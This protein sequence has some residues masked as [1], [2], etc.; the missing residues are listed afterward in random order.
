MKWR[1]HDFESPL[2]CVGHRVWNHFWDTLSGILRLLAGQDEKKNVPRLLGRSRQHCVVYFLTIRLL[3]VAFRC[4]TFKSCM[5]NSVTHIKSRTW[6][7]TSLFLQLRAEQT[8]EKES[9][10]YSQNE[11]THSHTFFPHLCGLWANKHIP[12]SNNSKYLC[13]VTSIQTFKLVWKTNSNCTPT[14]NLD[15]FPPPLCV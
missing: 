10:L 6:M 8:L 1:Q 3:C 11:G 5:K 9:H 14:F 12:T 15:F 2:R 4:I 7:L 13:T